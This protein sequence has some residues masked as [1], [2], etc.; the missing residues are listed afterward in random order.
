[1]TVTMTARYTIGDADVAMTEAKR[2]KVMWMK[3]GAKDFR[4]G[5]FFT[6]EFNGQWLF[7]VVFDDFAHLQKCRDVVI[8]TKDMQTLQANNE[9]AGNKLVGREVILGIDL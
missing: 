9:K 4:A 3:A 2:A 1:M 8:K 5:Q 6:G 7:H